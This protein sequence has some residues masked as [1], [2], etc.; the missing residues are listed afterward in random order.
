MINDKLFESEDYV[1]TAID[2]EKD[3]EIDSNYS[4]NLRYARYWRDGITRPFS[5]NEFKKKYE[6]IEKKVEDSNRV[7]HFAVRTKADQHLIG[8]VRIHIM[9]NHA[10]GWLVVAIGH[11]DHSGKAEEQIFPLIIR[12]AFLELNLFRLEVDVP[13]YEA[14]LGP[15]LE[16]NGFQRDAVNRG[17]IYHEQRYWDEYLYGILRPEWEAL[18]EVNA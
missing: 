8:F 14:N 16:T 1:L 6:K 11:P 4:L 15:I 2:Y 17:I 5:K 7:V 18:Q 13:A 3:P 10:V 12:F 9:W